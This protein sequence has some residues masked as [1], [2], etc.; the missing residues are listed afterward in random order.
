MQGAC[1]PCVGKKQIEDPVEDPIEV[2]PEVPV[3][4][5]V[6][7]EFSEFS[8]NGNPAR[9]TGNSQVRNNLRNRFNNTSQLPPTWPDTCAPPTAVDCAANPGVRFPSLDL[10]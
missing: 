1:E 9:I 7:E 4:V 10:T 8:S 6:V 3:P 5:P 2:E